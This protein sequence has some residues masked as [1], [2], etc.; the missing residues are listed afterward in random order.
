[1]VSS[2]ELA[3]LIDQAKARGTQVDI[4]LDID[5]LYFEGREVITEVRI[6]GLAGI[7]LHWM[8]ALTAA[9]RLRA[10]LVSVGGA[11]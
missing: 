6:E 2:D 7:G 4:H 8:P 10:A 11:S 9:E 1:M 5:A 3:A